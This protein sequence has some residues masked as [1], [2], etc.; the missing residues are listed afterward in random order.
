MLY[1]DLMKAYLT[2]EAKK[3][4]E[5]VIAFTEEEAIFD[6]PPSEAEIQRCKIVYKSAVEA[7]SEWVRKVM[8]VEMAIFTRCHKIS[9]RLMLPD[10]DEGLIRVCDDGECVYENIFAEEWG[11]NIQTPIGEMSE[12]LFN[13]ITEVE[14]NPVKLFYSH[15]GGCVKHIRNEIA[16]CQSGEVNH[17]DAEV[18]LLTKKVL[19]YYSIFDV[20][21]VYKMDSLLLGID[22]FLKP[23]DKA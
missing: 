7:M 22:E 23:R 18:M 2:Q 16:L 14:G 9:C 8:L 4:A 3:Y 15:L 21:G 19:A 10:D 17:S 13:A 20:L 12:Y 11:D 6:L 5:A 1:D